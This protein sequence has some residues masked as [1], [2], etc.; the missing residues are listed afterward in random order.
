M[1]FPNAVALN[2][3]GCRKT[4]QSLLS[5]KDEGATGIGATG[6]VCS[7]RFGVSERTFGDL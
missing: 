2:V 6:L 5:E 3:I 7:E 4:Q 1:D